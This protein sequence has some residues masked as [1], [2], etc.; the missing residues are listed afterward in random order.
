MFFEMFEP[1][2]FCKFIQNPAN[3]DEKITG[4]A[5]ARNVQNNLGQF[6]SSGA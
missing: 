2:V 5:T 3:Y 4:P 1:I 6:H